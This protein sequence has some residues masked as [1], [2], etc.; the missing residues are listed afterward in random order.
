[1]T[2][3]NAL[4]IGRENHRVIADHIAATQGGE[5]DLAHGTRSGDTIAGAPRHIG[6]LHTAPF[7]GRFTQASTWQQV[8][9]AV[10]SEDD[11]DDNEDAKPAEMPQAAPPVRMVSPP[12]AGRRIP[13][14]QPAPVTCTLRAS[15]AG[16]C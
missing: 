12:T 3:F 16:L 1:M 7:G 13:G 8:G 5:T 11:E 14:R 2:E 9:R 15:A 10:A 4:A 6:Q